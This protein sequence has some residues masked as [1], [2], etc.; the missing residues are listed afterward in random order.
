M[1]PDLRKPGVWDKRT[2]RAMHVFSTLSQY[3]SNFSFSRLLIQKP[4]FYLLPS[5]MK[6]KHKLLRR[7]K[8]FLQASR[9]TRS[10]QML[11]H[12][13]R[14]QLEFMR[15]GYPDMAIFVYLRNK[16]VPFVL[17]IQWERSCDGKIRT[18]ILMFM[19]IFRRHS[20]IEITSQQLNPG[21]RTVYGC[22]LRVRSNGFRQ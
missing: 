2:I 4:F 13:A 19:F 14:C 1:W 3:L 22:A 17:H 8:P 7:N 18:F 11:V 5:V 16:D 9:S 10:V 12:G 6:A 21:V 15:A 20:F